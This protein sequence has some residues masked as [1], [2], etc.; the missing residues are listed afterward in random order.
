MIKKKTSKKKKSGEVFEVRV[1]MIIHKSYYVE[2]KD[3]EEA[4][5]KLTDSGIVS[6]TSEEGRD[7]VYED[8][9][10]ICDVGVNREPDI[11]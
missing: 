6:S 4:I 2:A 3:G 1:T 8:E 10:N 11:K 5:E 9:Y 7:E